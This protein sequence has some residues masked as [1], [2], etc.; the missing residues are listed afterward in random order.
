MK[1]TGIEFALRGSLLFHTPTP[2][3]KPGLSGSQSRDWEIKEDSR[4]DGTS[5]VRPILCENGANCKAALR[6]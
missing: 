3:P 1:E 2:C 4:A 5:H 6:I